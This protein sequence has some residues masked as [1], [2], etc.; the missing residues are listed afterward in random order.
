MNPDCE[1]AD[2]FLSQPGDCT[3]FV[4]VNFGEPDAKRPEWTVC[5]S[6]RDYY[7]GAHHKDDG[8]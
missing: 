6:C 3:T 7:T 4:W 5:D 2:Q 1:H 8:R